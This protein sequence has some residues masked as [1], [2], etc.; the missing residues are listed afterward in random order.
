MLVYDA[1]VRESV[2]LSAWTSVQTY[3]DCTGLVARSAFYL[4]FGISDI[5]LDSEGGS[6]DL[7]QSVKLI[8]R[9]NGYRY[10]HS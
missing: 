8:A 5:A 6:G 1:M 4:V 2:A 9:Q 3:C 7:R 10:C